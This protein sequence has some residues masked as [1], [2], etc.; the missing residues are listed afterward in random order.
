MRQLV[1]DFAALVAES[2]TILEPVYEFGSLRVPGQE[3]LANL[4]PLFPGKEYVGCDMREGIGVDTILD[5]HDIDLPEDSV[6]TALCLDT[7]E[8]V[9][10]P[11]KAMAEIHRVLKPGGVVVISSVMNFPIHDYPYDYW[12]FT[13]EAF[14]SLL[15]PFANS[16]VGF[17][18]DEG[19]PHTVVGLGFKGEMPAM[20]EFD[21]SYE[22]WQKQPYT[23]RK[24]L[25]R[26]K[27]RQFRLKLMAAASVC[28][29]FLLGGL[30]PWESFSVLRGCLSG[31]LFAATGGLLVH[32]LRQ[33]PPRT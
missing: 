25:K 6:G 2:F 29:G 11:H 14:K 18:G 32:L 15:K 22:D 21:A 9:E 5:L 8:H 27:R 3:E 33:P 13:P 1:R 24:A 4:R 28:A 20:S 31:I 16:F 10:Y 7:L 12:R 26:W 19:F 23:G 17:A 30:F